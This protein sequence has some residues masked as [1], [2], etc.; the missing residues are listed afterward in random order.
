MAGLLEVWDLRDQDEEEEEEDD[1]DGEHNPSDPVVPRAV[2][3]E[4]I[5]TSIWSV[6]IPI[7]TQTEHVSRAGIRRFGAQKCSDCGTY[8]ARFNRNCGAIL[9]LL[10]WSSGWCLQIALTTNKE[11]AAQNIERSLVK[12]RRLIEEGESAEG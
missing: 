5:D 11:C 10:M 2:A 3:G 9:A 12:C 4:F 6:S 7:L 8:V 1:D